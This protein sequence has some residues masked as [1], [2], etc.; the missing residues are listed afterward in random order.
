MREEAHVH[1]ILRL[2]D[3]AQKKSA[4]PPRYRQAA[5]DFI[6]DG[7]T[8]RSRGRHVVAPKQRDTSTEYVVVLQLHLLLS[9]GRG[10]GRRPPQVSSER[11]G[12][13]STE[14]SLSVPRKMKYLSGHPRFSRNCEIPLDEGQVAI[15]RG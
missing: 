10:R 9:D 12:N 13:L 14:S 6:L 11:L 1:F 5:L 3:A 4:S 15:Q 2:I 8:Q 7:M